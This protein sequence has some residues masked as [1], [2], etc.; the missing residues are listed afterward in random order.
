MYTNVWKNDK[1]C[2]NFLSPLQN[3]N[4]QI[5]QFPQLPSIIFRNFWNTPNI[6]PPPWKTLHYFG[7]FSIFWPAPLEKCYPVWN[8]SR[9]RDLFPQIQN[10]GI[11]NENCWLRKKTGF[12]N[13]PRNMWMEWMNMLVPYAYKRL[14]GRIFG[15]AFSENKLFERI[16]FLFSNRMHILIFIT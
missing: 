4:F 12:H 14:A 3:P 9:M 2:K 11:G 16:V 13:L 6:N 7:G 10:I 5:P 8:G 1:N 15:P